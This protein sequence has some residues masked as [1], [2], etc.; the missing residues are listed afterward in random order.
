MVDPLEWIDRF[1]TDATRFTLARGSNPGSDDRG[2]RGLGGG[3][4]ELLQQAVERHQVRPDER[5][6]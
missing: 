1:G 6:Q 3:L 2:Q 4:A 5:G